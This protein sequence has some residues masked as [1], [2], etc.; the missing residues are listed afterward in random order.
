ME[1]SL[2]ITSKKYTVSERSLRFFTKI[3]P[4]CGASNTMYRNKESLCFYQEF[5][6]AVVARWGNIW[7]ITEGEIRD[8]LRDRNGGLVGAYAN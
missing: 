3:C 4:K 7:A 8:W 6:W 5:K 2:A 1:T